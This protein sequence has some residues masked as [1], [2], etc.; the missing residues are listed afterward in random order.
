[1][2]LFKYYLK[3]IQK[4]VLKNKNVI[5]GL[6]KEN[7]KNI[8]LEK[9]PENFNFDFSSNIALVLG[10]KNNTNPREIAEKIK[11]ILLKKITDFSEVEIAGPGFINIK[12]SNKSCIKNINFIRIGKYYHTSYHIILRTFYTII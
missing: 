10:K 8:I 7:F 5:K 4:E 6:T 12:L 1:M 2:N 3:E 11:N 9:P